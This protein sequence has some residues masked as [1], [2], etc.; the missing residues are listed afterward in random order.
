[1]TEAVEEFWERYGSWVITACEWRALHADPERMSDAVRERLESAKKEPDLGFAYAT[2]RDVVLDAYLASART[3]S[4]LDAFRGTNAPQVANGPQDDPE[5]STRRRQL[6]N[7]GDRDRELLQLVLW[8]D[9][10]LAEAAAALRSPAE[11]VETRF[12]RALAK[13]QRLLARTESALE[14]DQVAQIIRSLKPGQY[15]R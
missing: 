11:R 4:I 1:M 15:R 9:L 13:Y 5:A 10:T 6:A 14:T 7:L 2:V 8:D 3:R 12:T